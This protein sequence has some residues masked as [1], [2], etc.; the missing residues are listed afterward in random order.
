[1]ETKKGSMKR[2]CGK[3]ELGRDYEM[4]KVIVDALIEKGYEVISDPIFNEQNF[5]ISE[6]IDIYRISE[7]F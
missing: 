3:I 2:Y 5:M 7:Y 4:N 6:T 1:M